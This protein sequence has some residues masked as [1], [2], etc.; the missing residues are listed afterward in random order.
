MDKSSFGCPFKH[1]KVPIL[2]AY[3]TCVVCI[4]TDFQA[5][6]HQRMQLVKVLANSVSDPGHNKFWTAISLVAGTLECSNGARSYRNL[7][8]S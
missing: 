5:N 1:I 4:D 7:Y 8:D 2:S 6:M 3:F